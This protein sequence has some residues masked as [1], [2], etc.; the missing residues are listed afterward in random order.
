MIWNNGGKVVVG[1]SNRRVGMKPLVAPTVLISTH[2]LESG[3]SQGSDESN[4]DTW[5]ILFELVH[6]TLFLY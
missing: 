5:L 6:M 2:N 3:S 4:V 1:L